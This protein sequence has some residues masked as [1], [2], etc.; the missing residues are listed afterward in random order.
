VPDE[1]RQRLVFVGRPGPYAKK[2]ERGHR[3]AANPYAKPKSPCREAG[4]EPVFSGHG[5]SV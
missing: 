5:A 1:K 3:R 2:E 4:R